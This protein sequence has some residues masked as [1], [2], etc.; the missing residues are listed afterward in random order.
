M[1]YLNSVLLYLLAQIRPD[2][3]AQAGMQWNGT[4]ISC[5]Y[6]GVSCMMQ[7][8]HISKKLFV[9]ILK[10][11]SDFRFD[12]MSTYGACYT[13]NFNEKNMRM[14]TRPGPMHGT[15]VARKCINQKMFI[16]TICITEKQYSF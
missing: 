1:A 12:F 13:F 3:Q 4:I 11:F 2:L 10:D 8:L 9:K 14:V 15:Y 5:S 6:D 7:R 16:S